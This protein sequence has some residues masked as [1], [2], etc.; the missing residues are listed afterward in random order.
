[1]NKEPHNNTFRR[2]IADV[3]VG[4]NISRKWPQWL[5]SFA[6]WTLTKRGWAV[7]GELINQ[8]KAIL[9][10]APHTS[11]WDFFIGIF[12]VFSF[13]LN[14]NFFGKHSIFVPPLGSIVRRLGGIPI[15]RSKAHGVVSEIANKIKHADELILALAPEGTRSPIYPWKTGFMHIARE[16]EVPIQIIGLDYKKKA[17]VLGP[18]IQKVTNIDEQMQTIYAFYDTVCGKYPENCITRS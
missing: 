4:A 9:A 5:S 2:P 1:M 14:I 8:P 15:K 18:I 13:R 11:N 10:V 17:I 7:E 12:I 6:A 3:E 16:A